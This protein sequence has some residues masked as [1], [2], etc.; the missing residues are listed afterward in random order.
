[1][2]VALR[3]LPLSARASLLSASHSQQEDGRA[4][5]GLV[6]RRR[7]LDFHRDFAQDD[8]RAARQEGPESAEAQRGRAGRSRAGALLTCRLSLAGYTGAVATAPGRPA[9]D[10]YRTIDYRDHAHETSHP[11]GPR[12]CGGYLPGVPRRGPASPRPAL[13][14]GVRL[15]CGFHQSA[16]PS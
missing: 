14:P 4:A 10:R 16:G 6:G 13:R 1:M 5:A 2:P 9:D 15:E 11:A 8:G 12:R 7:N 3:L